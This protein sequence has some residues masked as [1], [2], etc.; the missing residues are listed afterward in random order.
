M[1]NVILVC[2]LVACFLHTEVFS[3]YI[4]SDKEE[5]SDDSDTRRAKNYAFFNRRQLEKPEFDDIF[6]IKNILQQTGK[7]P[8][9]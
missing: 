8:G 1:T 7:Q 5:T 2:L 4:K 9:T 3:S 6:F